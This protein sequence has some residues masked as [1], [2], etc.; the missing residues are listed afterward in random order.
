MTNTV[1]TTLT[2]VAKKTARE[3]IAQLLDGAVSAGSFSTQTSAPAAGITLTVEGVGPVKLPVGAAEERKLVAV[4]RPAMFGLGEETLIDT[5]VRDTWEL[6]AH[7]VTLGGDWDRTL[8][9]ALDEVAD[10]LDMSRGT[11]LRAELHAML[12]YGP[13]QFFAPHQDSEKDDQMVGTLVVSLPSVHTGGELIITHG[14]RSETYRPVS[15]DKIGF[16]AFYADCVHEVRPVR[17]GRR[18]T[19]TFN[20]LVSGKP[21]AAQTDPDDELADLLRE[22]FRTAP[23]PRWS[24]DTRP[25]PNRLVVLLDHEY[26]ERGLS[27]GLF[28]GRDVDWVARLREAANRAGCVTAVA[29]AEIQQTMD[30]RRS[31]G[32]D[33]DGT[34][35]VGD[36]INDEMTLGWWQV[37][38]GTA[39]EKISLGFAE[40]ELCA[41]T[42][43]AKLKPYESQYEGYMGNYGNT[44]DRWYRRAAL[45]I[46]PQERDFVIRAE[47]EPSGVLAG[48]RHRL[49]AGE[50]LKRMRADVRELVDLK[51]LPGAGDIPLLLS[52]AG[53][54]DDPGL[55]HDLLVPVGG[56]RL[57][58]ECAAPLADVADRYGEEWVRGLIDEWFTVGPYWIPGHKAWAISTLSSFVKALPDNGSH[59][60]ADELCRRLWFGFLPSIK[61]ALTHGPRARAQNLAAAVPSAAAVVR[62]ADHAVDEF[63]TSLKTLDDGILDLEVPLARA[64]G[65]RAPAGLVQDA[66]RRLV[67]LTSTPAREWNDWSIRWSGCGCGDCARLQTFLADREAVE[68]M[69][70]LATTRREHV[71]G[72]M[73]SAELPVSS[74]TIR[75]GRPYVLRLVKQDDLYSVEAARR[76]QW[77]ADLDWLRGFPNAE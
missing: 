41:V 48:L 39:G 14:G 3:R 7:Q 1:R 45:V 55:A 37:A 64:L 47:A 18:V 38:N 61:L 32:W 34:Y 5:S 68:L 44:V 71:Q 33:D 26:S 28:K 36:L 53:G 24:G 2:R 6:R 17:T 21:D 13:E 51:L 57:T 72:R 69:W 50:D 63:V 60:I 12:V 15:R 73:E 43:I 46:W 10:G 40:S 4:A 27:S 54:L 9:E 29:L 76:K 62:T 8:S 19:L 25:A 66:V 52:I 75:K 31:R 35:V 49:D 65:V 22:H 42:P 23:L 70:P 11:R 67:A 58:S 30:A 77:A 20:V 74:Q 59:V 56:D 16:T